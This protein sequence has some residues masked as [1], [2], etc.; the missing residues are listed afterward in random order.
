MVRSDF[1]GGI[2]FVFENVTLQFSAPDT[3][4]NESRL[5]TAYSEAPL[6]GKET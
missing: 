5:A 1:S 3:D 4:M 6:I 2:D